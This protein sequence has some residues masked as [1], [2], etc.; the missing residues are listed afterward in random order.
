MV[1]TGLVQSGL[2]LIWDKLMCF[3]PFWPCPVWSQS[4]LGW[5]DEYRSSPVLTYLRRTDKCHP[6]SIRSNLVPT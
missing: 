4:E 6:A 5:K 3:S 1:Q 2:D